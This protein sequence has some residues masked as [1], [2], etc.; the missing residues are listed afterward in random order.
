[1]KQQTHEGKEIQMEGRPERK[2]T[3]AAS[4]SCGR[5]VFVVF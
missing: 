2:A 4:A 5:K 3:L 1:L